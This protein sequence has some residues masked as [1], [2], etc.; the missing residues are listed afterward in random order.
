MKYIVT[1]VARPRR[2][3]VPQLQNAGVKNVDDAMDV[4]IK[5]AIVSLASAKIHNPDAV[6]ILNCNFEVSSGLKAVAEKAGIRMDQVPFGKYESKEEFPWAITQYKFDSMA[7]VLEVMKDS[8]CMVLLDTDTVCVRNMDELFEEAEHALV[9]YGINHG[10]QQE[11]RQNMIFNYKELYGSEC[12]NLVH[13]GGELFAGSRT[14]LQELLEHCDEVIRKAR[15]Q[16]G[17]RDWDDEHVLSIAA[18]HFMKQ[19]VYPAGSYICRYWTNQFYL[20][21]TNY[22]YDPVNIWHLPAEKNY[23]LLVLYDYFEKHGSFPE[24][25]KMAKIMGLPGTGYKKW[26]PYRWKMRL[27]NRLKK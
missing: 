16:E 27:I 14:M 20:V 17:L 10:Y 4:Y 24:V 1:Q 8:D 3:K 7:H 12:G 2:H 13:Y 9:L 6:C 11:K 19:A 18:E 23:G 15:A 25:K 26:N 22:H 5:N 21:S